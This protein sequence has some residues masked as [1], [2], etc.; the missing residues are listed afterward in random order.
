MAIQGYAQTLMELVAEPPF[1]EPGELER[2]W[3]KV[4]GA[5]DEVGRL[6]EVLVRAPG[7]ELEAIRADAWNP[8]AGGLVDP[9]GHWFWLDRDPPDLELVD[10]QH[11]GLVDVLR[12]E[13]VTVHEAEALGGRFS[14]SVYVRDPF[15]TVPG[16]VIIGRLAP[17][18]RRGEEADLTRRLATLGVPILRTIIGDGV[19]EGGT[20]FKL[21]PDLCLFGESIRCNSNGARQLEETLRWLGIETMVVPATG[22]AIHLDYGLALVDHDK[23]LVNAARLPYSLLKK[24][25]EVGYEQIHASDDEPLGANLLTL[26]PGRVLISDSAPRS[27]EALSR[28]GVEVLTVPFSE[29]EKNGGGV[30]C[31]TNE[32]VRDAA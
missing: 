30:H 22:Y 2:T 31:S 32:L 8:T 5:S 21:R 4:W 20:V 6:R 1:H 28:A 26:R 18:M 11:R 9:D 12:A 17:A 16:G 23:A 27:A 19:V 24:L 25:D 15:V 29:I 10:A 13:G 14:K 3:G 7:A